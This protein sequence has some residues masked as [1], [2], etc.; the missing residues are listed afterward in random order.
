MDLFNVIFKTSFAGLGEMEKLICFMFITFE[1]KKKQN[2]WIMKF[3]LFNPNNNK[4]VYII[5]L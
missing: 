2:K 1:E 5:E 4:N 3:T